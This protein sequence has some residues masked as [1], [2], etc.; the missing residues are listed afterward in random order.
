MSRAA[1]EIEPVSRMLWSSAAL[2]GP[3]R[4]PDSDTM[5]TLTLAAD[6]NFL[7][8]GRLRAVPKKQAHRSAGGVCRKQERVRHVVGLA[9]QDCQ[10]SIDR[11]VRLASHRL[12]APSGIYASRDGCIKSDNPWAYKG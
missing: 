7:T 11:L 5:L 9:D 8:P 1:A 2:P 6:I 3:M 10:S 4:T 12:T